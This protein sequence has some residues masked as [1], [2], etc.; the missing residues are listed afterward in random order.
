MYNTNELLMLLGDSRVN[1]RFSFI[2]DKGDPHNTGTEIPLPSGSLLLGRPWNT[3]Q[4]EIQFTSLYISKKHALI[5]GTD[6]QIYI[7]DLRS[8]HGTH[9]NNSELLPGKPHLLRA[10][11]IVSLAQGV[12]LLRFVEYFDLESEGTIDFDTAQMRRKTGHQSLNID[13]GRREVYAGQH[14]VALNGKEMDLL[15][16]LFANRNRAVSYDEIRLGV[17][18]ERPPEE[19]NVPSVGSDEISA[20]VYRVRKRLGTHGS[21]LASVPRYGYRLDTDL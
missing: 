20:L 4:P 14:K 1:T 5:T 7:E 21:Q 17:W 12:V 6:Q 15:L 9:I 10:N 2:V 19:N 16:L 3:H 8:K 13:A 18:P 11:D